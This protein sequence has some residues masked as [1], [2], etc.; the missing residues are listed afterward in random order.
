MSIFSRFGLVKTVTVMTITILLVALGIVGL[1]VS[2]NI[3]TRIQEQAIDSQNASLRTAATIV[4]RD[5]P[6]TAVTWAADGNVERIEMAAIPSAFESHEMI[7]TIGRMTGQ[8]ATIFAW[9]EESKD[10]WRRTTNIIKPDGSRAVGTQLG[11]NGAVYPLVTQGKTFRGEAV[12]LGTPYYTIYEPIYAPT[13]ETI[14]ILYAGVRS[15]EIDAIA[16]QIGWTIGIVAILVLLGAT[17]VAMLVTKQVMGGIPRLTQVATA[18]A[19]G[20]LD[21][22]VPGQNQRN[23]IGSLARALTVLRDGAIEKNA[24]EAEASLNRTQTESERQRRE[25]EKTAHEREMEEAVSE[26]GAGL[27]EI[28]NGNLQVRITRPFSGELEKLRT[29][30]N[31]AAERLSRTM[32]ELSGE[33]HEINAGASEMQAATDDLSRR[34]EQQAASLEQ[35][36]AALDEITATVRNAASRAEEAQGMAE[37]AQSSTVTSREVVSNAVDAMSRIE[38]ASGEISKIINVIDEIAFQ[39]NLLAL[40]AG[41][42]A[43][44]AGEAG[45]GFAV[46]AQEV[47]ELAQRSASAAK[48]IKALITKSGEEVSGGVVLV[49]E[50]GKALGV[51]S[52]QVVAINEHIAAIATSA[53]EQTTGLAEINTAVNQMDQVTQQNAAMVEEATAAMHQLSASAQKL[54]DMIGRFDIGAVDGHGARRMSRAA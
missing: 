31:S 41:V 27:S 43:A 1:A 18:L 47:R 44:R 4:A 23:E 35:T 30:F 36:S 51:I 11:Q 12:I 10:F 6:G 28:S 14:G 32:V 37:T 49:N 34:T 19:D 20:N 40:N 17:A 3:G 33:T 42:E 29:D 50:T 16:G 54:T 9:D 39:T 53:R 7:D 13:G 38:A 46:V 26:L 45:R 5:L 21:I 22:E 52:E 24:L 48:D 25:A 8:T 2:A 15:S